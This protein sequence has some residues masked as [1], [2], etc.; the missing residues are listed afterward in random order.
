V[1][2]HA[3]VKDLIRQC[4]KV[5][6]EERPSIDDILKHPWMLADDSSDDNNSYDTDVTTPLTTPPG[7]HSTVT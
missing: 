5:K 6:A 3:G 4:L 1:F 2:V 7:R